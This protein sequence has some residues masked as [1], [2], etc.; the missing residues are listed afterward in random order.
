MTKGKP[1]QRAKPVRM[2]ALLRDGQIYVVSHS[3]E[4][5]PTYGVEYRIVRVEVREV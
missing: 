5:F 1:R 4:D 2:W 3:R